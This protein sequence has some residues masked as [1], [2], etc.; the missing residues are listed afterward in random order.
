M[1]KIG[2]RIC[3]NMELQVDNVTTTVGK[4]IRVRKETL[5]LSAGEDMQRKKVRK[6]L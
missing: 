6:A 1:D 5:S 2:N 3:K 4:W